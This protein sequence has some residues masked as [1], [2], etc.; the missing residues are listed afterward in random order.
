MTRRKKKSIQKIEELDTLLPENLQELKEF[1]QN[2]TSVGVVEFFT[3]LAATFFD[4]PSKLVL[5]GG[6]LMQAAMSRKF[7][8]Q[9]FE[10]VK[11]Y[12]T[13]GKIPDKNLNSSYGTTILTDLLHIIDSETLDREKFEALKTVFFKSVWVGSDEHQ[14]IVAYEYF[15]VCKKLNSMEILILKTAYSMYKNNEGH[16]RGLDDWDQKISDRLGIAKDL[17]AHSRIRNAP[18]N[19]NPNSA[20]FQ[21]DY[22][23]ATHGLTAL[24]VAI[25]ELIDKGSLES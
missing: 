20:V 13:A 5:S 6:R 24:G 19:Q 25:G 1:I 12:R 17:I 3:G 18:V 21:A 15:Q 11:E 8:N 22:N 23:G 14:Q 2:P 10:E 9:V 16:E 7:G 4:N